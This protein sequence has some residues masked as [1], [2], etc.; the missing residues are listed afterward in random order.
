L[1]LFYK[2]ITIFMYRL[3]RIAIRILGD[4]IPLEK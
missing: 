4:I 1:Y 3:A 2:S